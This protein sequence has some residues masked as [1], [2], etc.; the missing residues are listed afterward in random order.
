MADESPRGVFLSDKQLVFVF[1]TATV[2]LVVVFLCGI[3][4][5]RGV[6]TF[7][8]M[9]PDGTM[10]S[11]AQVVPDSEPG[12]G[13]PARPAEEPAPAGTGS[14]ALTYAQVLRDAKPPAETL[15]PP[16]SEPPPPAE[17]DA[18]PQGPA[19]DAKP[20]V[21]QVTAVRSRGEAESI[22][23]RLKRKGYPAFVFVPDGTDHLGF[24][25]VRVGPFGTRPEAEVVASRLERE[26]KYKPWIT[27]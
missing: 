4:V 26:E 14:D 18:A 3:M 22:V 25:R 21:V 20:L 8:G 19:E 10:I 24:Y 13:L 6:Q 11:T 16:V 9:T 17:R 12:A 1:M 27:R 5:G 23:E 15:A 7:R 2:V